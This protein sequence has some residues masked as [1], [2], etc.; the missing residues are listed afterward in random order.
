MWGDL[1]GDVPMRRQ[2]EEPLDCGEGL[3]VVRGEGKEGGGGEAL[4]TAQSELSYEESLSPNFPSD[5]TDQHPTGMDLPG[6]APCL[7]HPRLHPQELGE[8][9]DVW[10]LQA[11]MVGPME[12]SGVLIT[13]AP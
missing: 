12:G 1:P 5:V 11:T 7:L 6:S 10:C 9:Q 4:H 8:A 13:M 3:A 2:Q